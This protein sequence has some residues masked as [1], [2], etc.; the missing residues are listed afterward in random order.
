MDQSGKANQIQK[1]QG[2]LCE[3]TCSCLQ[4]RFT[5][6]GNMRMPIIIIFQLDVQSTITRWAMVELI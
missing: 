4:Q 1:R 3:G 5:R 6:V 2:Q